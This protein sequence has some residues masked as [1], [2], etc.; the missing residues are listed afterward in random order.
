MLV[1]LRGLSEKGF[2]FFFRQTFSFSLI[3]ETMQRVVFCKNIFIY[4]IHYAVNMIVYVLRRDFFFKLFLLHNC[5]AIHPTLVY[6]KGGKKY[7]G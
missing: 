1:K 5:E 3:K 7:V 6:G 4:Y 2:L